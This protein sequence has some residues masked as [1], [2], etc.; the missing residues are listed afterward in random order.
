[1]GVLFRSGRRF[2]LANRIM[3]N[4][5]S[6]ECDGRGVR[7]RSQTGD[8]TFPMWHDVLHFYDKLLVYANARGVAMGTL[9]R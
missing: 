2:R 4:K 7:V 5:P 3:G 6:R 9:L 8:T 1:M